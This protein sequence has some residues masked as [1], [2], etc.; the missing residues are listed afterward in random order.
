MSGPAQ[1]AMPKT[2]PRAQPFSSRLPHQPASG[3]PVGPCLVWLQRRLATATQ[4]VGEG[5]GAWGRGEGAEPFAFPWR[6]PGVRN[7]FGWETLAGDQKIKGG[8]DQ[9]EAGGIHLEAS[10][11]GSSWCLLGAGLTQDAL[12]FPTPPPLPWPCTASPEEKT[13]HPAPHP[14]PPPQQVSRQMPLPLRQAERAPPPLA[15]PK[16]SCSPGKN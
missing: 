7:A 1:G 11:R 12:P 2:S 10:E 14:T 6:R 9:G 3:G 13:Q 16:L 15:P 5:G 4:G 8:T